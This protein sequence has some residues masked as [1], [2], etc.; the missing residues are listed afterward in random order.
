MVRHDGRRNP[1]IFNAIAQFHLRDVEIGRVPHQSVQPGWY[2]ST[3]LRRRHGSREYPRGCGSFCGS[4]HVVVGARVVVG[5]GARVQLLHVEASIGA[6]V[7]VV[8]GARVV[9]GPS[10]VVGTS[11]CRGCYDV[12]I[13]YQNDAVICVAASMRCAFA[14]TTGGWDEHD[15]AQDW[16]PHQAKLPGDLCQSSVRQ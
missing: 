1:S 12:C 4:L 7:D 10:D 9:V 3:P 2:S 5:A 14:E 16:C 6:V 13:G 8:A 15:V 11:I